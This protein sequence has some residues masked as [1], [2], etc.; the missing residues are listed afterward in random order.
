[1]R[2]VFCTLLCSA[3]LWSGLFGMRSFVPQIP[4][5]WMNS[6]QNIFIVLQSF[7]FISPRSFVSMVVFLLFIHPV[8]DFFFLLFSLCFSSACLCIFGYVVC[9]VCECIFLHKSIKYSAHQV[10]RSQMLFTCWKRLYVQSATVLTI[11]T[12][13]N[14]KAHKKSALRIL[15]SKPLKMLYRFFSPHFIFLYFE[16]MKLD[17]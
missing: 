6:L 15:M 2:D 16:S 5:Y 7:S 1:M 10:H 17:L 9:Y 14:W 3:L 4:R 13:F 8:T 12:H 11:F